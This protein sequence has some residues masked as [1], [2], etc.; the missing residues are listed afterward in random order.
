MVQSLREGG[1]GGNRRRLLVSASLACVPPSLS[2]LHRTTLCSPRASTNRGH[3]ALCDEIPKSSSLTGLHALCAALCLTV[4]VCALCCVSG[5]GRLSAASIARCIASD[6]KQLTYGTRI[7]HLSGVDAG[8]GR[9]V[10]GTARRAGR[11]WRTQHSPMRSP[12]PRAPA[13]SRRPWASESRR[14]A[15]C[16]APAP[17]LVAATMAPRCAPGSRPPP[18]LPLIALCTLR[19]RPGLMASILL[20]MRQCP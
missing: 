8:V 12:S 16:G 9:S 10:A 19:A 7:Q 17:W 5:R 2:L 3:R 14:A 18:Q 15:P 1:G 6:H 11:C 20:L 4:Q 13:A